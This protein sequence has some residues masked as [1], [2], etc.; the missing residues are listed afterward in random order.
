VNAF[1]S[2]IVDTAGEITNFVIVSEDITQKKQLLDDLISAKER[3]EES[4]K[5]KSA[6]LANMSHEIRTP[7]NGILGFAELLKEP[8]LTNDIQQKYIHIIEKSGARMLNIINNIVDISKIEA[9][10]MEVTISDAE[11]N[12]QL[13]FIYNFFKPEV[14]QKGMKLIVNK[15]LPDNMAIIKTDREKVFAIFTNLVKNAIKYSNK[16]YIEFGYLPVDPEH[17]LDPLVFYVKDT[18]IG[19]HKDKIGIIFDRFRQVSEGKNRHYEGAGL[20]LSISKSYVEMLGG[21]I[22]VESE[23]D[24]GSCFY[25]TLPYS[26]IKPLKEADLSP[27]NEK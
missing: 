1:I 11:I 19:I 4:D 24:V 26:G 3:A 22:W 21:K 25:F 18:G 16:G 2:P 14:E 9:G 15:S 23:A 20:G 5:L 17:E 7:M 12:E 13:D 8:D 27:T 10:L 6:F